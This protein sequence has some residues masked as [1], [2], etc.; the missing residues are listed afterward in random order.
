MHTTKIGSFRFHHNG[1]YSGDVVVTKYK[2]ETKKTVT[3]DFEVTVPFDVLAEF[4]G[5]AMKAFHFNRLEAMSG[6]D[7]LIMM[8][9][10]VVTKNE[11]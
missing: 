10:G 7:Y 3:L 9:E 8:V 4:V 2:D 5:G 6:R 11:D 1:D